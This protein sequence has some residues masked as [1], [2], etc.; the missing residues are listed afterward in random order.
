MCLQ[1]LK[2]EIADLIPDLKKTA[3]CPHDS[4]FAESIMKQLHK[5]SREATGRHAPAGSG[6][7]C[8]IM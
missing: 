3:F 5:C 2:Q 4:K 6:E 7:D 1:D 8:A